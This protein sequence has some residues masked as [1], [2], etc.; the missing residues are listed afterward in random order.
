PALEPEA[1]LIDPEA[2]QA[3]QGHAEQVEIGRRDVADGIERT[4]MPVEQL[5]QH[6]TYR[7]ALARQT[8]QD[9]TTVCFR[10][11]MMD[12]ARLDQLLQIVRDVRAEIMPTR[13][14]FAGG[15]FLVA[16]VEQQQRLDAVD[17][18]LI[19]AVKFV[20][21]YVEQLAV[22]TLNQIERLEVEFRLDTST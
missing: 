16:D 2:L 8:H 15:Q 17:L 22:Q 3:L 19:A 20:L 6:V 14:Q 5:L 13:A 9:R 12:V 18:A 4:Q 21:D 7:L 11:L 1:D 10:A